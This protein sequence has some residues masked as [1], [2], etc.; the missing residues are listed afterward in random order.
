MSCEEN[1]FSDHVDSGLRVENFVPY[2]LK[3]EILIMLDHEKRIKEI[4]NSSKKYGIKLYDVLC[5]QFDDGTHEGVIKIISTINVAFMM[6]MI[7]NIKYDHIDDYFKIFVKDMK[8][9]I[10]VSLEKIQ[11]DLEKS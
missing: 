3:E 1:R 9:N 5:T 6:F 7:N 4:N 8:K 2:K 10:K 11:K